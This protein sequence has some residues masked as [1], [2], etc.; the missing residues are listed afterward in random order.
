MSSICVIEYCMEATMMFSICVIRW[1]GVGQ[2]DLFVS[3][4]LWSVWCTETEVPV[5]F[6]MEIARNALTA[7]ACD[8]TRG[9]YIYRLMRLVCV[10]CSLIRFI[11]VYWLLA[12]CDSTLHQRAAVTIVTTWQRTAA[13]LRNKLRDHRPPPWHRVQRDV[14]VAVEACSNRWTRLWRAWSRTT[15]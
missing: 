12:A 2:R 10:R 3:D 8:R 9:F 5:V 1:L 13:W 4:V 11:L 14:A 15:D 6:R 7:T